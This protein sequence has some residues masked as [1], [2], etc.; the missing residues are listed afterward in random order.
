MSLQQDIVNAIRL[1]VFDV[2]G[3]F[4][5]GRIYYNSQGAE[6]KAF[7]VQ[8]GLG[9]QLL[10]EA[11]IVTAVITGRQSAV[12]TRRMDELGVDHVYQGSRDKLATLEELCRM[13]ALKPEQVAYMGDDL[14]DLKA[15]QWVGVAF[16]PANAY[17]YIREISHYVTHAKSGEGAVRE[18]SDYILTAQGKLSQ[19][20]SAFGAIHA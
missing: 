6:A 5:D 8:D 3:V 14:P 15:M 18:V 16:A 2:D 10:K 11:G 17:W 9:V 20:I 4:S 1:V 7:H 12:V 19:L 13:L